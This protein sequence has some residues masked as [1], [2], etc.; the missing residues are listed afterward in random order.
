MHRLRRRP[1]SRLGDRPAAQALV[2]PAARVVAQH[3]DEAPTGSRS[4]PVRRRGAHQPPADAALAPVVQHVQRLD[5]ALGQPRRRS[6]RRAGRRWRSRR[7]AAPLRPALQPGGRRDIHAGAGA[8]RAVVMRRLPRHRQPRQILVGQDA[9]IGAAPRR[10]MHRADR[11]GV[12]RPGA[13]ACEIT[14]RRSSTA[15]KN[16]SVPC[17][18]GVSDRNVAR[19]RRRAVQRPGLPQRQ[20][21]EAGMAGQEG[22]HLSLV[23]LVQQ[24]AGSVDQSPAGAH[25]RARARPGSPAC[26]GTSSARSRS[27]SRSRASGLRRQVPVPVHGASTSTRSKLPARRLAHLSPGSSRWRST[28]CTPARRSRRTAPSSR[29]A[30]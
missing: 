8:D 30:D 20:Q 26:C 4:P 18:S 3:P 10:D 29:G 9:G 17:R 24:R 16:P 5:L 23:L 2:E 13:A 15:A 6:R 19:R 1:G 12:G 11:D 7:C 22:G 21:G 14:R 28:L 25:Q 27:V